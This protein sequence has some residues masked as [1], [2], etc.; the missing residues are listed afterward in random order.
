MKPLSKTDWFLLFPLFRTQKRKM[1]SERY[2]FHIIK[3]YNHKQ[4]NK[5]THTHPEIKENEWQTREDAPRAYQAV[6]A[7]MLS[8]CLPW[9]V[10]INTI[11][12]IL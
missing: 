4:S 12:R 11:I 9:I 7:N 6:Y 1:T 10:I 8:R 2:D 5:Q 3:T